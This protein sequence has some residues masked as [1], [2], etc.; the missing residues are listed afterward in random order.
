[1]LMPV[2]VLVLLTSTPSKYKYAF[3]PSVT[4]AVMCQLPSFL[5]A[6][7]VIISAGLANPRS[8]LPVAK[9]PGLKRFSAQLVL[10]NRRYELLPWPTMLLMRAGASAELPWN[11]L[12]TV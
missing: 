8:V 5:A 12:T 3:V 2:P 11:Q 10:I 6:L 1:M 9:G 4:P 7:L